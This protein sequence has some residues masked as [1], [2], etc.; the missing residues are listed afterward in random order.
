[1]GGVGGRLAA[2]D[3]VIQQPRRRVPPVLAE[4]WQILESNCLQTSEGCGGGGSGAVGVGGLRGRGGWTRHSTSLGTSETEPFK[5]KN[6]VDQLMLNPQRCN[7]FTISTMLIFKLAFLVASPQCV[8]FASTVVDM[9]ATAQVQSK[10][11][12]GNCHRSPAP[13][14]VLSN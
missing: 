1:M 7:I 8:L 6:E 11:H 2:R 9:S 3:C 4:T 5:K 13:T 14:L 12:L 10:S